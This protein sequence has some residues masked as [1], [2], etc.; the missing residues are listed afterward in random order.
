MRSNTRARSGGGMPSKSRNGWNAVQIMPE[1]RISR[2][3]PGRL[4]GSSSRSFSKISTPAKPASAIARSLVSSG[5]LIDTVAMEVF[6]R[7]L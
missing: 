3:R 5:P 4:P 2:P 6:M 1:S 7:M